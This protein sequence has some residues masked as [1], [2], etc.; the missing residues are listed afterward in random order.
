MGASLEVAAIVQER[1]YAILGHRARVTGE[2]METELVEF[3]DFS[4]Y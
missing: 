3:I 1:N 4:D 2:D